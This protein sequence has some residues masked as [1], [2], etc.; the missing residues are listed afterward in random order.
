MYQQG[1][2]I[3]MKIRVK[4]SIMVIAII[5]VIVT[6]IAV[7]LLLQASKISMELSQRGINY[8]AGQRVEYWK[9]REEGYLRV[10]HTLASIMAEYES[11]PVQERR[12]RYD[13][14][15]LGTLT[16]EIN[17]V[18]LYTI[19]KPNALDGMDARYIGRTGSSPTGQ[20]AITYTRENGKIMG[21]ASTD[22]NDAMIHFNGRDARKERVED[23]F[24][25]TVNGRNTL[26][27]RMMVPVINP[28]TNEVVGGVGCLLDA[29][30]VQV[31]V[32]STINTYDEIAG[33]SIYSNNGMIMGHLA[34][35]RVGKMLIDVDTVF[36]PYIQEANQ[37]VLNGKDFWCTTYSPVLGSDVEVFVKSFQIGN[38]DQTWSILIV[39]TED[40]ILR[41]VDAITRFT[42]ILAVIALLVAVV[43]VYFVLHKSTK[44]IVMVAE[45]LKDIS[46]GEGDLTRTID[47][48]SKDE[49]GDLAKYFNQT[50]GKIKNLIILIKKEAG[51]LSEIGGDLASNM[52]E[53][54]AAVNE[55]AANTQSIKS[56][57][58]SQSASVTETNATMEQVVTNINK[59]NSHIE[60]QSN[61]ISQASSAIEEMVANINSVTKTLVNNSANVKTLREASDVGR[62]G[63]QD[64]AADIQEIARES[65]GLLEIN[66][67]MENIA[68]QTN[69]LSM[70]A[71]IEAAH[72][73]DAGR[74]FAVVAD[75]IRKLAESS[76]E[77]SKTIGTV[78]KRIKDSI[79]KITLSTENVLTK[80]TA[81]DSNVR[82][83][84]D[85]E[86]N[87]R[88]AME[89]QGSGSKQ[90]LQSVGNLNEISRQV[91]DESEKMLEGSKEVI[92][93]SHNLEKATQEI[94][95]GM[96]EMATGADQI[97]VAVHH[98]NEISAKN[99]EGIDILMHEVS[100]FKVE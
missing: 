66:A 48:K 94:T 35:D 49:I 25:R 53:T 45:T 43:I 60:N 98:V 23:P 87:I 93:E 80:F 13:D 34:P 22:I 4:L 56:R 15:L 85:E 68:S 77:Q 63:L 90:L 52:T 73:G 50:L 6:G 95:G 64:V 18:T 44:P 7:L 91:K 78:L 61:D 72:A 100:R 1:K 84:A 16:T 54:A 28:R 12:N 10:L 19:W 41:E 42:I 2:E 31:T 37:A 79:D 51:Q 11:V 88:N 38:S 21:R 17:M 62:N 33:F 27:L 3:H 58:I 29:A 59:L 76:G 83:V 47:V 69:L 8:L 96:N 89:E 46:E 55:I 20:Y 67:V 86:E 40:Y 99:R 9:G 26:L 57:V 36:G 32:E 70:N 14:I 74:G 97:N 81:I 71:A 65:E 30:V 82:I 24:P 92:E 5:A 75:E 39:V